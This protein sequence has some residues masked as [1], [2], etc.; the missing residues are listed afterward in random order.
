MR[1]QSSTPLSSR[2]GIKAKGRGLV[3]TLINKL[4]FELHLPSYNFCGPGT[5]LEKRLARGDQGVNKLDEACRKHDIAY[6]QFKD[7]ESRHSAD[8]ELQKA[9]LERLKAR[10]S[11]WKEKLAS[12]AVAGIMKG[13]TT[14]GMGGGRKRRKRRKGKSRIGMG[15]RR[16][17]GVRRRRRIIQTPTLGGFVFT[18]PLLLSALG[19][20]GG[21]AGGASAIAK[22]VQ[23][24]KHADTTLEET[25]RHNKAMEQLTS[26]KGIYLPF[27]KKIS[28][29]GLYLRPYKKGLGL[30]LRPYSKNSR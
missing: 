30:Y 1:R 16:R 13:K 17:M 18:V 15:T 25:K 2:V 3:N 27:R 9:A 8:K 19:A 24:K 4:P 21:L 11:N 23:D 7:I 20:L 5:R 29:R 26:G 12:L 6:S 10:D 14:L 22:T 28:G